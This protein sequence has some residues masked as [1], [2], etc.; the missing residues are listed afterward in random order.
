M[1]EKELKGVLYVSVIVNNE[2]EL[3]EYQK[4]E[5]ELYSKIA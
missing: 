2:P 1:R 3:K 4:K 5:L